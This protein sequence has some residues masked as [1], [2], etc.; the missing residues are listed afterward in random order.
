MKLASRLY[1]QLL[2][3]YPKSFR[4]EHG[5]ELSELFV[6]LVEAT[7]AWSAA[8]LGVILSCYLDA[9]RQLPRAYWRGFNLPLVR[10]DLMTRALRFEIKQAVRA[11]SRQ[12]AA[13]MLVIF[14]L[15]LG[16]AANTTVFAMINA[17]FL[18]PLPWSNSSELVYLNETAPKWNLEYTGINYPD[19]VAWQRNT[20]SFSAMALYA[21]G[22]FNFSDG[23]NTERL[24]GLVVTRD[25]FQVLGLTPL[26]G[27]DFTAAEDVPNAPRVA[28]ISEEL[29]RT[30]FGGRRDV[31]GHSIRLQSE[32]T[33]I[34]GVM[35]STA[36]VI[37]PVQLWV[38]LREDPA[39]TW[40]SYNYDGI[41]RLVPGTT[42]EQARTDLLRAHEPIWRAQDAEK[43]VS[44]RLEPLRDRFV[45]QLRLL[46]VALGGGVAIVLLVACAN[47]SSVML[48]R[49]TARQREI[50]IRRALGAGS[51]RIAR[52]MLIENALLALAGT[53]FGV[54]WGYWAVKTLSMS[55]PE[56]A[57]AWMRFDPDLRLLGFAAAVAFITALISG[58]A[59]VLQAARSNVQGALS[60][61]A[62]GR[63]SASRTNRRAL[64][65]LVVAEVALA[66]VLLVGAGL[67]LRAYDRVRDVDPG[68][69]ARDAV[70][71]QISLPSVKYPTTE[72]ARAFHRRMTERL[73][74]IPGVASAAAINCAPFGCHRGNFVQIEGMP[75]R[76]SGD[77]NPVV[78]TQI[79]SA[80][81][82]RTIG[83]R[84][85][86]GRFINA[87]DD[88][89]DSA[90]VMVVNE[91]FARTFLP[92]QN[93]IGKRVRFGAGIWHTVVGLA[94]DVKH[95]GLDQPVRPAVYMPMS[96]VYGTM[97]LAHMVRT[98]L[99]IDAITPAI[100]EA[101]REIDPELP[102]FQLSTIDAELRRS[103][104]LRRTYSWMLAVFAA[105]ALVLAVGGIYGVL[106]YVVGQ[107]RREIGIRVALGAQRANVL[108]LVIAQGLTVAILGMAIG[109]LAA[110][111]VSR[112]F[113]TL[114]YGVKV[115]DVMTYSVVA[116][117]LTATIVVAALVPARRA[118][119]Y[120]PLSVLRDG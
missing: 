96:A 77:G 58:I 97:D 7:R 80:D 107:R 4:R 101:V 21:P 109:L 16:V 86:D 79:A 28:V 91:T 26:L 61:D 68:F 34:V 85:V 90:R 94:G 99:S 65:G 13:T 78:L 22:A 41:A 48:A 74:A 31:L 56:E 54:L 20:R 104:S 47:V 33:T 82:A 1:R 117:V 8:R 95:Y 10:N 11:L 84:M 29:W 73:A 12:P 27:R 35:P 15:T 100:R 120:P 18:R 113:A 40:Q 3:L 110:V 57:P 6:V 32:L 116:T 87:A 75:P 30:R 70:V 98:P 76:A 19:F 24:D 112:L 50:G 69:D 42:I 115:T 38:P 53:A 62:N 49:A 71:F 39:Q 111:P 92:G 55:L 37:K 51:G 83:L 5:A 118:L 93:V 25:Y 60:A 63:A 17:L 81:Y 59:P 67:F 43:F 45:D 119:A 64:N 36:S 103:L 88:A 9:L 66:F 72:A 52:Q 106:S 89:A 46:T 2:R 102:I 14:M 105:V 23:V 114:L 44:P 108:R